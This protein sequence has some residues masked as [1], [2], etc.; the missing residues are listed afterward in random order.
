VLVGFSPGGGTD[1]YGRVIAEGLARHIEGKPSVVVQHMPGAGSVIAMNNYANKVPRDGGTL[2]IGTGQ[3]LMRILL[4]V[5]GARAKISDFQAL[6]ATPMGRI[7]YASPS[8]GIK[9]VK[10]ILKPSEPLILGV[11]EVISTIDAVLGLTVLKAAF[12]PVMG[13]PGKS[14][15][16]L[17]FQRNEINIDSQTTPVFEQSVRPLVAEGKAVPLFAQGLMDG[18]HL[19][20]DPA[21][22]DIPTVADAYR[23]IYGSDPAGPA[24]DSYKAATRAVGNGGKILMIHGDAPLPACAA[25]KHAVAAMIKDVEFL[26]MSESALEGYGFNT[27][28][29]LE[30]NIAAI[31]QMEPQSIA[32]LQELFSRDFRMK[33]H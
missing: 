25:V 12:R 17:A 10:D 18:E 4:G 29:Q 20:R 23:D 13:Y 1:L 32:W 9:S 15:I 33:F 24:W 19:V 26:K 28:E 30:A 11:P 6:V 7:T 27:G 3:L 22:P 8:A 5:D 14:D 2:I 16:R 31:G 21:A